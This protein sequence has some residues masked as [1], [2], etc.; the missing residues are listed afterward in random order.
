LNSG[1]VEL[2]DVFKNDW[3]VT[4]ETQKRTKLGTVYRC[5]VKNEPLLCRKMDFERLTSYQ[6]ESYFTQLA[7]IYLLKLTKYVVFP[8]G[9][10]INENNSLHV[11][12]EYGVS[13]HQLMFSK[14]QVLSPYTKL[15]ILIQT[16]KIINTFHRLSD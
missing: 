6:I 2:K 3:G 13:L 10:Y 14:E 7:Y 9:V 4:T 15:Q 8:Q 16:A 1:D 5:F 12:T 11:V